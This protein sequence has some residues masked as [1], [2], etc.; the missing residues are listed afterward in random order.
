MEST[1]LDKIRKSLIRNNSYKFDLYSGYGFNILQIKELFEYEKFQVLYAIRSK[2]II[3]DMTVGQ[4]RE[5]MRGICSDYMLSMDVKVY[6]NKKYDHNF[7]RIVRLLLEW[8]FDSIMIENLLSKDTFTSK[9][10]FI[11]A[12]MTQ[13]DCRDIDANLRF[14]KKCT[15]QVAELYDAYRPMFNARNKYTLSQ[16]I[17]SFDHDLYLAKIVYLAT[18]NDKVI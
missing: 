2:H 18:H 4:I 17:K 9:E 7:M 16:I 10:F 15:D 14:V 8:D 13:L 3:P 12:L 5:I 11:F 6:A 1:E